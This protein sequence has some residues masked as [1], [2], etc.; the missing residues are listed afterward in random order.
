MTTPPQNVWE[1]QNV[2]NSTALVLLTP[3]GNKYTKINI[4]I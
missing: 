4:K 1:K 2:N 3:N